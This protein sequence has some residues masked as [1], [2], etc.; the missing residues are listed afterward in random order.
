MF[1]KSFFDSLDKE[2]K[3]KRLVLMLE[4]MLKSDIPQV[5]KLSNASALMNS[6]GI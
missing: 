5:T 4:R 1:D 2:E 6:L 3:Y